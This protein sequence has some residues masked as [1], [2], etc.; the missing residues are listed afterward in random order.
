MSVLENENVLDAFN[1][2]ADYYLYNKKSLEQVAETIV[3]NG[4]RKHQNISVKKTLSYKMVFFAL[5]PYLLTVELRF[6]AQKV[7]GVCIY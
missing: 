7:E 2:E 3:K 5:C 6:Y 4:R 1:E